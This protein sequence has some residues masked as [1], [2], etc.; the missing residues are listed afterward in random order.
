MKRSSRMTSTRKMKRPH[1][2]IQLVDAH[3]KDK[4]ISLQPS[5]CAYR[6]NMSTSTTRAVMR[7]GMAK[8]G[9]MLKLRGGPTSKTARLSWHKK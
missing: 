1:S 9:Q 6:V 7:A 5:A 4:R 8:R 2:A 3:A